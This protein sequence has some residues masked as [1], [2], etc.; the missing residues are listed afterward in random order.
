MH[1]KFKA[2][3]MLVIVGQKLS[4]I[5]TKEINAIRIRIIADIHRACH[6]EDTRGVVGQFEKS[7]RY[8]TGSG[9][10]DVKLN[11]ASD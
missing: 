5:T 4:G 3:S 6:G 9:R 2:S 11:C 8:K 10:P 7:V 1:P